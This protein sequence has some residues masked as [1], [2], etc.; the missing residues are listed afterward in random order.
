MRR[1]AGQPSMVMKAL[2]LLLAALTAASGQT[3]PSLRF[4][5]PA[6]HNPLSAY[7]ADEVPG[8]TSAIRRCWGN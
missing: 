8:R 4:D 7:L 3:G 2:S 6:S 1:I 5:M